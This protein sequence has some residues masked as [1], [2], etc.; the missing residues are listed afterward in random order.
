MVVIVVAVTQCY[1]RWI[2]PDAEVTGPAGPEHH[3]DRDNPKYEGM[4]FDEFVEARYQE[5]VEE[6]ED[7]E[8][9]LADTYYR[10]S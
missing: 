3:A 10:G 2:A 4:T 1:T 5:E 9:A 8:E 6:F 7:F